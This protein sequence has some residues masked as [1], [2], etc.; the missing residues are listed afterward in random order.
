[1]TRK[2][3]P[4][5]FL[6]KYTYVA[7]LGEEKISREPPPAYSDEKLQPGSYQNL[8]PDDK[9]HFPQQCP[10]ANVHMGEPSYASPSHVITLQPSKSKMKSTF[11]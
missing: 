6:N 4:T 5:I 7:D 8:L 11:L 9:Q 1:M 3:P 10:S 2:L